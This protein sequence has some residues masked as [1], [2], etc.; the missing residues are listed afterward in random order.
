MTVARARWPNGS[1][2]DV[3]NFKTESEANEWIAKELNSW[4]QLRKNGTLMGKEVKPQSSGQQGTNEP[5]KRPGQ[6]SQ[7]PYSD[8]PKKRPEA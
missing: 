4:L 7:N 1:I 6:T 2:Q 8:A 3:G 5:W